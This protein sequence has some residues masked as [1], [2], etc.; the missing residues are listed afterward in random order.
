MYAIRSY[1]DTFASH[2]VMAGVDITTVSRLLGHT[3]LKMTLSYAH[4]AP[5]H[6]SAAIE[7][8]SKRIS[9]TPALSLT[10]AKKTE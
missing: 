1:Y 4:L 5:G 8:L 7:A 6:L 3:T 10:P 9:G 2:L